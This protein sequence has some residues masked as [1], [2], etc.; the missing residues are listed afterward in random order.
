MMKIDQ[1]PRSQTAYIISKPKVYH[2]RI[3]NIQIN[4]TRAM[5]RIKVRKILALSLNQ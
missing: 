2:L 1:A 4:K 5:N 3:T